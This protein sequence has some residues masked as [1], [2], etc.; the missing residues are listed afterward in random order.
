MKGSRPTQSANKF[1]KLRNIR[2]ESDVEQSI[3]RPLLEELGY[4]ADYIETKATI[5][6]KNIGKKSKRRE[7]RPDFICYADKQHRRPVL[8]I[9]A[10]HPE[11]GAEEGLT[12]AQL[13]ASVLRRV[14]TTPKPDQYCVGS[15]GITTVIRHFD[16][17]AD[18]FRLD[19]SEIGRAHV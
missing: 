8:I 12:D 7:Y 18:V 11:A 1:C 19:F 4:T 16:S 5:Q 15:N 9:D 2:N 3:I 10:K 17:D 14:L 13:Y 6:Q